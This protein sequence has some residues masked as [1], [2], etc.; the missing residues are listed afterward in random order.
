MENNTLFFQEKRLHFFSPLTGKFREATVSCIRNLY[1]RLNGPEADYSYHLTKKDLIDIFAES[2]RETPILDDEDEMTPDTGMPIQERSFWMLRRLKE[3]GWIE[4]YMDSGKMQTA[5]RFTSSGRQF[6]V[7]FAQNHSEIITNTQHTRSTLSHLQSFQT[8]LN[9]GVISVSDLMIA[10]KLS[11]EII[12][13]FNEIIEDIVDERRE[14]ISSIDREIRVAKEAGDN[15]FEFM[16]KRIIPDI[17]VRFSQD[18]VERYKND[19]LDHLDAIRARPNEIKAGIEQHLRTL[20]PSLLRP[21]RPSILVWALNIIEQ[22]LIAAC[23][24]KMPEL[25]AQTDNFI[26][27]AQVLINHLASLAFGETD[28]LSV[29]SLVKK[30]SNL[31]TDDIFKV[32]SDKRSRL[33]R[34]SLELVNPEKVKLPKERLKRHIETAL[35]EPSE[36]T[37]DEQRRA[38][39]RQELASAF[40][41]DGASVSDFVIDQ[42]DKFESIEASKFIVNDVSSLLGAIHA[43]MIGSDG[44]R[45]SDGFTISPAEGRVETDYYSGNNF[46]ISYKGPKTAKDGR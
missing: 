35:F 13:D 9:N 31:D 14:L 41:V 33:S 46:K 45:S 34:L 12:S 7:P 42:L 27:R 3:A 1:L 43:P 32:L 10:T 2:I 6:A 26:R 18:S 22:R 20:Y 25:R 21:D 11:G 23:D 24:V 38:V 29:F 4:E 39:I 37:P 16:E 30:L 8:H 19:I 17:S 44:I 15:F 36:T 40:R 28:A 5:Y